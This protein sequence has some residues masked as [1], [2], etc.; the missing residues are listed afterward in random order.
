MIAICG[1]ITYCKTPT[2]AGIITT[3]DSPAMGYASAVKVQQGVYFVNGFFVNN[4]EQLIVITKI[5][6]IDEKRNKEILKEKNLLIVKIFH[7]KK[8]RG[9]CLSLK[10]GSVLKNVSKLICNLK[11]IMN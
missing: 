7:S 2:A 10:K 1:A 5:D 9:S 6:L 8:D 3:I 11:K 4:L